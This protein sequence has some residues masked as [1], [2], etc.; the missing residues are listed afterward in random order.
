[1]GRG[2]LRRGSLCAGLYAL[3][4]G[5]GGVPVPHLMYPE[6]SFSRIAQ[7]AQTVSLEVGNLCG[8][9]W[10][11]LLGHLRVRDGMGSCGWRSQ[12]KESCTGQPVFLELVRGKDA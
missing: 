1:M 6:K 12:R 8:P 5:R 9:T 11:S 10:D 3:G 4:R 2:R 7:R